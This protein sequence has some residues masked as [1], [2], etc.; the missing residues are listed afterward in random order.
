MLTEEQ[1]DKIKTLANKKGMSFSEILRRII[2]KFF[3]SFTSGE[4]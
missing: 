2:D 1:Q 4:K 3:E